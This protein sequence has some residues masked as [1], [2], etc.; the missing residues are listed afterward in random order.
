MNSPETKE[1]IGT[2]V[3]ILHGYGLVHMKCDND[4][5]F[6]LSQDTPGVELKNVKP[7]Q[8][9]RCIVAQPFFR[10]LRAELIED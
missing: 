6:G 4:S 7:G 8:K 10:V 5:V 9:Y 1:I 2:V 3:D